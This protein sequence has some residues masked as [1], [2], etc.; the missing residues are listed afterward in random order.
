MATV[1]ELI[2]KARE[3]DLNAFEELVIMYQDRVYSHCRYLAGN[4]DDAQDLAQEVFVQ[5]YKGIKSFRQEAN[6]GTWLHRITLNH[7]I[8][9]QRRGSKIK[10]FSLDEP[11][12]YEDG[13]IKREL[14]AHDDTPLEKLEKME[15]SQL[16][17]LILAK[18]PA[19]FRTVLILREMEG[20]SYDEI[21]QMLDC[22][23]GT[24]KSRISRGRKALKKEIGNWEQK[25]GI[26]L[27]D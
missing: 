6:F 8:N 18:L 7:W 9:V 5:V 10:T 11:L 22:S 19:E 14:Q 2:D 17:Q 27:R 13:D 12:P 20:Y 15:F 1:K 25:H 24:V 4:P 26:T 3:N 23:L 16:I 21:A